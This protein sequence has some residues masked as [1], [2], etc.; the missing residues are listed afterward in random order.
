MKANKNFD[1]F[2]QDATATAQESFDAFS[3]CA[4]LWAKGAEQYYKTCLEL[5]Q[6]TADELSQQAKSL[7]ASKT[8]NEYAEAQSKFAQASFE[9]IMGNM[10]RLSEL[11]IRIANDSLQPLNEQ[12]NK[13]IKKASD[14]AA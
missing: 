4:S 8:M 3:Q 5:G 12:V 7:L 2:T 10:T 9:K 1:K 14:L 6:E 13:T 11:G